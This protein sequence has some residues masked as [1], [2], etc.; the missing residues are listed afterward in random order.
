MPRPPRVDEDELLAR[1]AGVFGAA[2]Y[3]GASLSALSRAAGLQRASLYHRFPGGKR[4]MVEE[5]L[6]QAGEW[7]E[8]EVLGVLAGP[9]RPE[10]R[11]ATVARNLDAF[12]AGG[13]KACLLN[14]LSS[15]KAEEGPFGP[16]IR[17]TLAALVEGLARVAAEAGADEAQARARALR[18]AAGWQGSLVLS[19]GLGSTEP[20]RAF[21]RRLPGELLAEEAAA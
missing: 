8:R 13:R 2:G 7:M 12:Y 17:A 16:A 10:E 11:L 9:G 15:P 21:L 5:V 1:L 4:Q 14:M 18:A 3:E 20:F 6:A 19:L